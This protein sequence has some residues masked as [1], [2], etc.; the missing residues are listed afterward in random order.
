MLAPLCGRRRRTYWNL[1]EACTMRR[2]WIFVAG[3]VL[4]AAMQFVPYGHHRTSS[5]M[6]MEPNWDSARTRELFFR[7][8]GDC[9]SNETRWPWYSHVA[10]V[11]WFLQNHV[12]HGREEF[13]VSRWGI[14]E[15]EGDEAAANVR[16]HKMPLR[17]YLWGHPEARLSDAERAAFAAGLAATF[18]EEHEDG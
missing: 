16:K 17:S 8:C 13:N 7:A 6:G 9:H 18:G 3:I 12:N 2:R 5:N 1:L 14:G 15:N 4:F 11:S 10:P